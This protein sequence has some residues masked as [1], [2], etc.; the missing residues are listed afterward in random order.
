MLKQNKLYLTRETLVEYQPW[1][2][3]YSAC[4]CNDAG[5]SLHRRSIDTTLQYTTIVEDNTLL[6]IRKF[7]YNREFEGKFFHDC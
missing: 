2:T 5:K 7:Q 4:V 1:I 6:K 3:R